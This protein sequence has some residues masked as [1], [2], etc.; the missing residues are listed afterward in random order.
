MARETKNS[1]H[2][3]YYLRAKLLAYFSKAEILTCFKKKVIF[4][5]KT[6]TLYKKNLECF[7]YFPKAEISKK[8]YIYPKQK[9]LKIVLSIYPEKI[10]R[11]VVSHTL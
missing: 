2:F 3:S 6:S 11:T 1:K 9:S 7:L 4:T 8:F 5:P 10:L